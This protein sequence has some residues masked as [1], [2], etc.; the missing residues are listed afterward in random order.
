ME[1][2]GQLHPLA[3]LPWWE[4]PLI[5]TAQEVVWAP[6]PLWAIKE[7]KTFLKH[8]FESLAAAIPDLVK[9]SMRSQI[10]CILS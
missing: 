6:E 3:A 4:G 8:G 10:I 5:L 9:L 1:V 2:G 7:G